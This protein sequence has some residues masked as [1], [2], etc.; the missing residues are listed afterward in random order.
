MINPRT[1]EDHLGQV[2]EYKSS[3]VERLHQIQSRHLNARK[4]AERKLTEPC[5]LSLP[6]LP[7]AQ[8]GLKLHSIGWRTHSWRITPTYLIYISLLKVWEN[9]ATSP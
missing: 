9:R 4:R 6:L 1:E 3:I 5:I 8:P 2:T 7:S